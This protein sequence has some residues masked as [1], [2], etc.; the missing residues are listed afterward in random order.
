[1]SA[2]SEIRLVKLPD[3]D[4]TPA[5]FGTFD[6]S[7]PAALPDNSVRLRNHCFGVNAGMRS[8]IGQARAGNGSN[9]VTTQ[10]FAGELGVGDVPQSD[11]VAQVLE[12]TATAFQPGDWVVHIAPWRTHDVVLG[13]ILRRVDVNT[14]TPADMYLT[15]LGH[16]AFT[17][18]VGMVEVGLVG[19]KD[20]VYVSA[21]A[22]GV[23]SY[24]A[25]IAR[26]RG[27]RVIGSAGSAE[28]LA[29]LRDDLKLAGAFNYKE[30]PVADA[31]AA[32][33]PA[34]LSLYYDNVGG[35]QL[36]AAI[37]GMG[38]HGHIVLC[39][40]VS[41]YVQDARPGPRNLRLFIKRRL[42]M[43]GFTVLEHASARAT[44]EA[45]M[46]HWLGRNEMVVR[47]TMF[48]GLD[49]LP[50]AFCSLLAGRTIGRALVCTDTAA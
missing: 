46:C 7:V 31:L 3:G 49:A 40:M 45:I 6:A 33:A 30:T 36:E 23:G 39:G 1:M 50:Q 34:G 10:S 43:T 5:E 14:Q 4:I 24:A 19:A 44:F 41:D 2:V 32:F 12:S 11:A 18:Y 25:Q 37:A 35:E 48:H 29:Y 27:A 20:I 26:L 47:A 42:C 13:N 9:T 17:A 16:T 8:R 38:E 28:K 21:A 15:A 22:G